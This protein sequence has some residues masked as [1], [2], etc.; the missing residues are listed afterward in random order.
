MSQV[1]DAPPRFRT[2]ADLL[3]ELGDIPA[4]RVRLRPEPGTATERDVIEIE[5]RENRLCELIDGVLVEKTVGFDESLVAAKLVQK[6]MNF[7]EAGDLGRVTTTGGMIRLLPHQVRI[8]DVGFFARR[9]LPKNRS[10]KPIPDVVPDLAVEIL[11]KGNSKGEMDRKL[12]EYFE[13]GTRLVWFI[14]PRTRSARVCTSPKEMTRLQGGE[15]LD[16]GDLLP[17]FTLSLLDLFAC[18]D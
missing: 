2:V 10:R 16:G 4:D 7:A 18:L 13:A 17:G 15:S 9:K 14:D 3:R 11:S 6:L 1:T 5:A 8:P 12:R